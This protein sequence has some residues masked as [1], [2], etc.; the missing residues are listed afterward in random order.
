L[1]K[2]ASDAEEDIFAVQGFVLA[3]ALWQQGDK[4]QAYKN[5]TQ[6]LA[7]AAKASSANNHETQHFQS[8]AAAM[9]GRTNENSHT[10]VK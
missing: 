1:R 3:M 10:S 4:E 2:N 6:A 8:E 5:Y 9:L 7:S